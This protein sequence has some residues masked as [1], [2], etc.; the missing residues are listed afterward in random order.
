MIESLEERLIMLQGCCHSVRPWQAG[1]LGGDHNEAQH[2][3]VQGSNNPMHQYRLE[4]ELL[5]ERP[6]SPEGLK[7]NQD[8]TVS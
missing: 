3:L 1:E 2:K 4:V 8:S 6:G 5:E 7:L